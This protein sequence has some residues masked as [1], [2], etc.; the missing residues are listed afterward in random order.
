[1]IVKNFLDW[2]RGEQ[3]PLMFH[4]R[5][6]NCQQ[7]VRYKPERAGTFSTCPRCRRSIKLP[8]EEVSLKTVNSAKVG[9]RIAQKTSTN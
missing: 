3:E 9:R 8:L 5:C 6:Q 2:W 7:K 1:M 4:A